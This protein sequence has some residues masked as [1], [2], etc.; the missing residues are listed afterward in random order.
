M[1]P[2]IERKK[3]S[4]Q[5]LERLQEM[6][7]TGELAPNSK[8]PSEMELAERFGVSR[9]P[10]REALSVLAASGIIE[11]KQ[12]GGSW[13]KEVQLVN[14]LEQVSL[15]MV[16]VEQVYD[17]LEMRNIM[18]TE[19]AA[20]AALRHDQ[21]ELTAL[22]EA[23]DTFAETVENRELVGDE[24]DYLFHRIIMQASHNR[25]LEQTMEN[26]SDLL[27][28]ALMFS[29]KKNI[30]WQRKREEVYREHLAIF[31]AIEM[32]NPEEARQAMNIHLRNV[33]KKL[34]DKRV[35]P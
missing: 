6:I 14:M 33:R 4:I 23:L 16:D 11:S 24:A 30:G 18:E 34:G 9:S 29:L 1:D 19:A 31:Q 35:M 15:D 2:A 32:R 12:G 22:K 8:L 25:F 10:I 28:K 5:V 21:E 20:L 17:L 27:K 7:K 3:V 26:I 13:V